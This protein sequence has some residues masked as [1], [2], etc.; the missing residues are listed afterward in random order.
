MNTTDTTTANISNNDPQGPYLPVVSLVLL[1]FGVVIVCLDVLFAKGVFDV[2]VN[3]NETVS[4]MLAFGVSLAGAA[5]AIT[6]GMKAADGQPR[7]AALLLAAWVLIGTGMAGVRCFRG[8]IVEDDLATKDIVLAFVMIFVYLGGLALY[9]HARDVWRP[10]VFALMH[11]RRKLNRTIRRRGEVEGA[12]VGA[13]HELADVDNG[14]PRIAHELATVQN[15]ID[16]MQRKLHAVARDRIVLRLADPRQ[17]SLFRSP[18][19]TGD[20]LPRTHRN[21]TQ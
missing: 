10:R 19:E 6:A 13:L 9:F 2:L 16:A 14:R 17:A 1:G 5:A 4:W 15:T 12:Y 18:T 21:T 20:P 7:A 3:E 8:V 11:A